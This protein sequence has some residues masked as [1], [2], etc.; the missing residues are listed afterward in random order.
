M[1]L[2]P[3]RPGALAVLEHMLLG[4]QHSPDIFHVLLSHL[5]NLLVTLQK[6]AGEVVDS[7]TEEQ[8]NGQMEEEKDPILGSKKENDESHVD[9]KR[10]KLLPVDVSLRDEACISYSMGSPIIGHATVRSLLSLSDTEEG[11]VPS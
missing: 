11:M 8:T 3:L 4:Y 2:R 10:P 6:E 1:Y 9:K 7:A 5:K